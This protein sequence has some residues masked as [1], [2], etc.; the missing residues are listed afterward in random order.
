MKEGNEKAEAIGDALLSTFSPDAVLQAA[1]LRLSR[2]S[3][4]F[5]DL[6]AEELYR[7][8]KSKLNKTEWRFFT[9]MVSSHSGQ[10][11][12]TEWHDFLGLVKKQLPATS[13]YPIAKVV[14]ETMDIGLAP[15]AILSFNAEPL[16]PSLIN[17]CW[18][19]ESS[20]SEKSTEEQPQGSKKMV[21]LI[22]ESVST[23]RPHRIPYIFCHGLLP[24]PSETKS[25]R[26]ISAPEK[27]VFSESDYLQ[28]ASASYSWQANVFTDVASSRSV[29]FVGVSMSD[30]NMRRWLSLVHANRVNELEG[31]REFKGES[32]P[33]Y[34]IKRR[35][36]S[37]LER[38]WL[39]A[40]VADLGIRM[41]W[42]QEWDQIEEALRSMIGV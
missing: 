27:L 3:Q 16:L 15:A 4:D 18:R 8:P 1:R 21:D 17:A 36:D 6:L 37:H 25:H 38:S 7:I 23:R 42:I 30:P 29:I 5:V 35:P 10:H 22:T 13:S 9:K 12:A 31:R 26:I 2:A 39:E 33:H 28:L 24:V 19:V 11:D 20:E 40:I 32:A 41:A 34:W 14:A